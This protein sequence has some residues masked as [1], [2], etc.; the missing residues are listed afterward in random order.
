M[1]AIDVLNMAVLRLTLAPS[2]RHSPMGLEHN[3]TIPLADPTRQVTIRLFCAEN[4][5]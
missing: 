2:Q 1:V 5:Y 3:R 4:T